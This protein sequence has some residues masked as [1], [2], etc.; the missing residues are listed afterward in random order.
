MQQPG[1]QT[2]NGEANG[3][4]GHHWPLRWRRPWKKCKKL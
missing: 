2:W 3:G 4:D 1:G